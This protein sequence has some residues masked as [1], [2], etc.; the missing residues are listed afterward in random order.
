MNP[1]LALHTAARRYCME[2]HAHWCEVY[3]KLASEGGDRVG[4]DYTDEALRTFPRYNVLQAILVEIER[5]DADDLP[6]YDEWVELLRAAGKTAESESPRTPSGPLMHRR[7]PM[8]VRSFVG[9]S[10]RSSKNR[11]SKWIHCRIAESSWRQKSRRCGRKYLD[12]GRRATA[13]GIRWLTVLILH[14]LRSIRKH[15]MR[16]SLHRGFRR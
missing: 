9:F 2:Q 14:S 16:M 6:Q 8:S 13:I 7:L 12:A 1:S 5:F 15:S 10:I 4:A 11:L 3:G